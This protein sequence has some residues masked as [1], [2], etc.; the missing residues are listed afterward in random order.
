MIIMG[1]LASDDNMNRFVPRNDLHDPGDGEA[2]PPIVVHVPHSATVIP[3]EFARDFVWTPAERTSEILQMTDLYMEEL[4][5]DEMPA[6]IFPVSRLVCDVERFR[7]DTRE[8]MAERGMG[9]TYTHGSQR[10]LIR[11]LSPAKREKILRR[12]YDPH[13]ER[14]SGM[15]AAAL[16]RHDRCLIIDLHSFASEALPYEL[17]PTA[18]RPDI[19]LGTDALHTPEELANRNAAFFTEKGYSVTF[20]QPFAGTIV[21]L[22][23]Y[24]QDHRVTSIM[25]EIKRGL[26]MDEADGTKSAG[27]AKIQSDLHALQL[28][29]RDVSP[30]DG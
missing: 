6:L 13:H 20:D 15:V 27:F 3:D 2:V 21:P 17:N 19:C 8:V 11:R 28:M 14:L 22:R 30:A 7:D 18:E 16:D 5:A 4:V 9:A 10:Q 25:I 29:L 12:F 1:T 23:Y 24:R 26:Y